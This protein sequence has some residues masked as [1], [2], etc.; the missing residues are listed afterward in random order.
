[1]KFNFIP[2]SLSKYKWN[3]IFMKYM[4][5]LLVTFMV[6]LTVTSTVILSNVNSTLSHNNDKQFEK[7]ILQAQNTIDRTETTI[8]NTASALANNY[9]FNIILSVQ[10]DGDNPYFREAFTRITELLSY[11]R[12]DSNYVSS[13]YIYSIN[14]NYVY[15]MDGSPVTSN[16][17]DYFADYDFFKQYIKNKETPVYRTFKYTDKTYQYITYLQEYNTKSNPLGYIAYNIDV[18]SLF[19]KIS[20]PAHLV[21]N[22]NEILYSTPD[23]TFNSYDKISQAKEN[24]TFLIPISNGIYSIVLENPEIRISMSPLIYILLII[25]VIL[26][27]FVLAYFIAA[28]LYRYVAKICELVQTPFS[29]IEDEEE[30]YS[31]EMNLIT[32]K[33][34]KLI[35]ENNG[36]SDELTKKL[37]K[38]NDIQA[39][40]LQ[41]QVSPHFL[42][43]T[44][45]LISS[46][47]LAESKKE[48]KITVVVDL[49]S[50][51]LYTILDTSN[52][53]C[54]METELNYTKQY[55]EIQKFKYDDFNIEWHIAEE[56]L[57]VPIVKFTI[58]PIIENAIHH[59]IAGMSDGLITVTGI[60]N[61]NKKTY[62][63]TVSDNGR[64]L[65][66]EREEEINSVIN[67]DTNPGTSIGLWNTNKRLKILLGDEYGCK[68]S[69]QSKGASVI[70]TLPLNK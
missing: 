27:S 36:M 69:S 2:K 68:I 44:L 6:I 25:M 4:I 40:A 19:D 26:V 70:I 28:A 60:E 66:K 8:T 9:N 43:N 30:T 51:M 17:S 53:V 57:N 20:C 5:T 21:N 32:D 45:N 12:I 13:I 41:L 67:S 65:T 16:N 59:G 22:K 48:T 1:M 14:N 58:Q 49:L 55:V 11:T 61:I 3:S 7:I 34:K 56:H 38:L 24:E 52:L 64:G 50:Q 33:L 54:S 10:K 62:E 39:T 47:S 18:V 23:T 42:F 37:M 35:L 46:L 63:I 15:T 31:T 29:A